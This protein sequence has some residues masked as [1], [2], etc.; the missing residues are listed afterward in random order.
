MDKYK[1]IRFTSCLHMWWSILLY[2]AIAI[3]FDLTTHK[4]S[5]WSS[6]IISLSKSSLAK[7]S[8]IL[9]SLRL[10]DSR[11]GENS[12]F[13][14]VLACN[15]RSHPK[16]IYIIL[17]HHHPSTSTQKQNQNKQN[18]LKTCKILASLT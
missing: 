2:R 15:I 16:N 13:S 14:P 10:E 12:S 5:P 18:I 4:V 17:S 9:F 11:L 6:R 8:F 3:R 1:K 7:E